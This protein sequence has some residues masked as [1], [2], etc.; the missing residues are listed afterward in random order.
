MSM[1][2]IRLAFF[3]VVILLP[4]SLLKKYS[5]E[6]AILLTIAVVALL[7]V[8]FISCLAPFLTA[9]EE[10][11]GR[12][13]FDRAHID[14]LFRTVAASL[15]THLCADLCRDGGSQTL[16]TLAETAGTVAVLLIAMPLLTAVTELLLGYFN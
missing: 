1:D 8:R 14:I 9:L 2:L 12:A 5:A 16:A 6:Q 15:V 13:G 11:F 7:G 10:L 4:L 3:C